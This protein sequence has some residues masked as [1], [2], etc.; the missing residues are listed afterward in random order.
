MMNNKLIKIGVYILICA[1]VTSSF[2]EE[3]SDFEKL[4]DVLSYGIPLAG[5]GTTVILRDWDGSVQFVYSAATAGALTGV[6]KKTVDKTRPN[7]GWNSFPSGHSTGAF[8]GAAFIERRYGWWAGTPA[9]ALAV[10]TAYSRMDAKKHDLFDVSFGALNGILGAYIWTE[11]YQ[12]GDKAVFFQPW[13]GEDFLG[14]QFAVW[15]DRD[16]RL[17]LMKEQYEELQP[18]GASGPDWSG[19]TGSSA[20]GNG[21]DPTDTRSALD[22]FFQVL[23]QDE[24]ADPSNRDITGYILSAGGRWEFIDNHQ[25]WLGSSIV[26]NNNDPFDATGIGDTTAGYLWRFWSADDE[27]WWYPTGLAVGV[28]LAMPTGDEDE[29]LGSGYWLTRPKLAGAWRFFENVSVF[30]V[31]SWYQSFE[32]A[33]GD[34][35]VSMLGIQA[36]LQYQFPDAFYASWTPE[37]I[38]D[39]SAEDTANHVMEVGYP[40][41]NG[42]VPYFQYALIGN[43]NWV[44]D[45]PSSSRPRYYDDTFG[46]GVR[47]LF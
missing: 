29:G 23:G 1:L 37:F 18:F 15:N 33:D 26:K 38:M 12:V 19:F 39:S 13:N 2:A 30:P 28:D 27:A 7:A 45:P 32:E 8:V 35:E 25:V 42:W 24:D 10:V 3:R 6:L 20:A 47:K 40:M 31:I 44:L 41:A 5:L 43:S 34:A 11:P 22:V 46:L 36:G 16:R 14:I 17:R 9:Y 21:N 4:G